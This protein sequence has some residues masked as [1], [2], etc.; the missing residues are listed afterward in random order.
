MFI[1]DDLFDFCYTG[2]GAAVTNSVTDAVYD[3]IKTYIQEHA[4][5]PTL[6]EIAR[7]CYLST[8]AVTRHLNRLEQRGKIYR[9]P[10]RARGIRLLDEE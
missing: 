6:R 5:P 10:A 1:Q 9:E 7:G 2:G 8:S 3:F 4:Y